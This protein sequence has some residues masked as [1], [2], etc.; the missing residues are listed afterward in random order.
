MHSRARNNTSSTLLYAISLASG[1]ILN[2][3]NKITRLPRGVMSGRNCVLDFNYNLNKGT[4]TLIGIEKNT[5]IN[6]I[7]KIIICI[8][9]PYSY[10]MALYFLKNTKY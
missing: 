8:F 7:F 10:I 6:N 4:D 5:I 1:E 3:I 9:S 2:S